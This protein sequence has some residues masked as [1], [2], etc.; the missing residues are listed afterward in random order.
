MVYTVS[1]LNIKT[2]QLQDTN[3]DIIDARHLRVKWIGDF[4][5]MSQSIELVWFLSVY[6]HFRLRL[7]FFDRGKPKQP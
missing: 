3:I 5:L 1:I 7:S 6:Y 4:S 2:T